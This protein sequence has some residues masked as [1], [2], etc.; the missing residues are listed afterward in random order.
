MNESSNLIFIFVHDFFFSFHFRWHHV[1]SENVRARFWCFGG[2]AITI[3]KFIALI[4]FKK[5]LPISEIHFSNGFFC[6]TCYYCCFDENE[7]RTWLFFSSYNKYSLFIL[8]NKVFIFQ[9][10]FDNSVYI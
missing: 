7:L 8:R 3:D 6:K 10:T 5:L 9:M 4:K 1:I 2:L